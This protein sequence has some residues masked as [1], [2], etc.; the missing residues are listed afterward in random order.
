MFFPGRNPLSTPM[1]PSAPH[2]LSGTGNGKPEEATGG[3]GDEIGAA[4]AA[5]MDSRLG[6]FFALG[7]AGVAA[8]LPCLEGHDEE[9]SGLPAPGRNQQRERMK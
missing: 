1:I 9:N 4:G 2:V 7:A 3:G 6:N 8:G 5:D